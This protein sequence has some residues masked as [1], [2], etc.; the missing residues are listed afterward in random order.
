[1]LQVKVDCF[2]SDETIT[3]LPTTWE[4]V[5]EYL[6]S[7]P[8][9]MK[10]KRN[11]DTPVQVWDPSPNKGLFTPSKSGNESE[12]IE[13]QECIPVG[14]VPP[15][16]VAVRGVSTRHPPGPATP[17][18]PATT[19]TRHPPTRHPPRPAPPGTRPPLCTE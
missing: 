18:G 13:V 1:M 2:C 16:A 3:K 17:L 11:E 19:Q 4:G 6:A 12:K 9:V 10:K 15:T 5:V 7:C 14:C 8:G